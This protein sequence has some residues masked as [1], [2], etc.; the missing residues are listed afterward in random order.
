MYFTLPELSATNIVTWNCYVGEST[1]GRYG[2]ILGGYLLTDLVLNSKLS[3]H[4]IEANDGPFKGSTAPMVDMGTY[5][6]KYS[7]K[8]KITPE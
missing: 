1:N 2:I 7:N 5:K 8:G 6:F 3:N 4:I